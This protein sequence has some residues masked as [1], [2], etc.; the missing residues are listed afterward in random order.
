MPSQRVNNLLIKGLLSTNDLKPEEI[1]NYPMSDGGDG[2]NYTYAHYRCCSEIDIVVRNPLGLQSKSSILYDENFETI[3]I[4]AAIVS[5]LQMI[6][7]NKRN[8]MK[9]WSFGLADAMIIAKEVNAKKIIIGLGGSGI[10]DLGLGALSTLGA[11]LEINGKKVEIQPGL[12]LYNLR[13]LSKINLDPVFDFLVDIEVV[14]LNDVN[15]P[16]LGQ[17]GATKTFGP[18]KGASGDDIIFL[19]DMAKSFSDLLSCQYN[20][21]VNRPGVGAA[22]GFSAG[23]LCYDQSS[24]KLGAEFF[25]EL[26]QLLSHDKSFDILITGEGR[27]DNTTLF[28]KLP[29][30]L[31]QKAKSQYPESEIYGV[32]GQNL[33]KLEAQDLFNEIHTIYTDI[34]KKDLSDLNKFVPRQLEKIGKKIAS[35]HCK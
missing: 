21:E 11:V 25:V 35:K 13:G 17:S 32:F 8:L 14:L 31:S 5:G 27:F 23:F 19:E 2:M 30:Y 26:S 29:H 24:L 18:Q 28:Q 7:Q 6:P 12:G 33:N 22:G 10:A 3:I 20:V 34:E 9:S 1:V 4:E 15:N 16:L